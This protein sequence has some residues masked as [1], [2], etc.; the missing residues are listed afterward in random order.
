MYRIKLLNKISDII[1]THLDKQ[2]YTVSEDPGRCDAILVR[3]AS[4]HEMRFS[5]ELLA[6]ARAGAGINNVP[7]DR[8]SESG[9]VVFNTPG[10]NANAVKELV[11]CG[12]LLAGRKVISGIEWVNGLDKTELSDIEPLVE[13]EK[14]RFVGPELIGRKLGVIGLG[15]VGVMVANA[16]VGLEME[17]LG[18]DPYMSVN[19]AWNLRRSVRQARSLDEIYAECDFITLHVPLN[20]KTRCMVGQTAIQAMKEDAVLLNF[21]RG[22]LVDD[23]AVVEALHDGNLRC[24]VTDF[25]G[26]EVIGQPGVIAIPHLGASTPESEDNCASMA[27]SQLRAFLEEG[28]ISNSVNFPD[29]DLPRMGGFR[30]SVI[31]KNITNMVGQMTAVLACQ[32]HN[33]DHMLNK[34]RGAWAYTLFDLADRPTADCLDRLAAIEGVVRVRLL[35]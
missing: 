33:I 25:P 29:C 2:S 23:A 14:G 4:L 15:A 10:A 3:S 8:C 31:N 28:A 17:V 24:Y 22:G 9:I 6:I 27:A 18:Y 34:S 21:A 12:M 35:L 32:G 1:Y 16:A 30:V 13:K 7:L 5:P 19:A 11:L 26:S 20:D